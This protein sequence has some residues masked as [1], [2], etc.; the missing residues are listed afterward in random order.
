MNAQTAI[1]LAALAGRVRVRWVARQ[2]LAEVAHW[3]IGFAHDLSRE[4]ADAVSACHAQMGRPPRVA[5]LPAAGDVL[6][7]ADL[8]SHH[9]GGAGA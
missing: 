9:G 6:P 2:P 8:A 4:L 5:V 7:A 3:G 1:S